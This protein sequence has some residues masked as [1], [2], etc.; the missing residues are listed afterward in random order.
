MIV[1]H[2]HKD[3]LLDI[4]L[5]L[6]SAG[7]NLRDRIERDP[8]RRP[9]N[10]RRLSQILLHRHDFIRG[11]RPVRQASSDTTDKG[12]DSKSCPL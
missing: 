5:R 2:G 1:T 10:Q 4:S 8:V 12:G 6:P 11:Y 7:Q 9:Q 3:F